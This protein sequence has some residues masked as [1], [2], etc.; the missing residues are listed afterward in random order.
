[1]SL[2]NHAGGAESGLGPSELHAAVPERMLTIE[3]NDIVIHGLPM[4]PAGNLVSE[5]G[6]NVYNFWGSAL[7]MYDSNPLPRQPA[8]IGGDRWVNRWQCDW[9]TGLATRWRLR[10]ELD[11]VTYL[12]SDVRAD[13]TGVTHVA[14][15]SVRATVATPGAAWL[16]LA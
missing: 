16:C 11:A 1:M 7:V 2:V 15:G 9:Y 5:D 10:A 14:I 13:F 3:Q 4:D 6:A 8:R 12:D